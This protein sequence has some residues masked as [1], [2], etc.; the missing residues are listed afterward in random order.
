MNLF[1]ET[2]RMNRACAAGCAGTEGRILERELATAN[3]RVK[4]LEALLSEADG[5]LQSHHE[6]SL[7][8]WVGTCPV[9]SKKRAEHY[10]HDIFGR[11]EAALEGK[12]AGHGS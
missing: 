5:L 9:C 11:I 8:T 12:E 10:P 2:P 3:A 6:M 4:E 7:C 1:N